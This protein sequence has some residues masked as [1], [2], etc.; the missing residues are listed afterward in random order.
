MRTVSVTFD[1]LGEAAEIEG[2]AWPDDQPLGEHFSVVEILP[3]LLERLEAHGV[4]ATFFVE[5]I[6][7]EINPAALDRIRGEMRSFE[8]LPRR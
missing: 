6:N 3:R 8:V 1:N 2:G 7:T 4:R 5:A